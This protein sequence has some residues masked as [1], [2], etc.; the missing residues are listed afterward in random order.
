ML[1]TSLELFR[2][3]SAEMSDDFSAQVFRNLAARMLLQIL[4]G[5]SSEVFLG[6]SVRMS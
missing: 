5:F 3:A 4:I 6:G 1:L 2:D